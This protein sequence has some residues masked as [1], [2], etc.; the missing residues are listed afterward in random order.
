[1]KNHSKFV[2]TFFHMAGFISRENLREMLGQDCDEREIDE[3]IKSAD[4]GNDGKSKSDEVSG[5]YVLLATIAICWPSVRMQAKIFLV[6][7][8]QSATRNFLQH[9]EL[10]LSPAPPILRLKL[11]MSPHQ[12]LAIC[13]AWTPRFQE[14][15]LILK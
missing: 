12:I 1:M 10:L 11:T 14:E 9:L 2:F 15:N 3:I 5:A 6:F 13:S 7:L 4:T 8:R